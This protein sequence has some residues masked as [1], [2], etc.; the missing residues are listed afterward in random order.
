MPRRQ[1]VGR[2]PLVEDRKR[3][4]VLRRRQVRIELR[5]QP[6]QA[7][8]LVHNRLRRERADV[9]CHLVQLHCALK[10]LARQV[11]PALHRVDPLVL[12][13][14]GHQHLPDLRHCA[15]RDLAQNLRPNRHIA[16][17]E[18]LQL[19]RLQRALDHR[20]GARLLLRRK[21]HAHAQRRVVRQ[22]NARRLQQQSA[23]HI[24]HQAHAV[25]RR[26]ISRHR[27]AV[28]QPRQRR[29]RIFQNSVVRLRQRGSHKAHATG[30]LIKARVN[31]I[32]RT[33]GKIARNFIHEALRR[34]HFARRQT[35][36]PLRENKGHSSLYF[37]C[38]TSA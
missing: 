8:R 16:P 37:R 35:L 27:P 19:L 32:Y 18:H 31:K 25:A 14:V 33:F 21:D 38:L 13:V 4:H 22:L 36:R 34:L 24:G 11:Q 2:V 15:A 5:Q 1:R 17:R 30:V 23:R 29:Q 10:L 20:L 26:A 28:L 3:R 9:A 12:R 7:H 6:A